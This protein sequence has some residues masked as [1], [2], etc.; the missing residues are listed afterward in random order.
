MFG[1]RR[2]IRVVDTAQHQRSS[3]QVP[4]A[5]RCHAK[6]GASVRH[7]GRLLAALRS[8][9]HWFRGTVGVVLL[10]GHAALGHH[11]PVCWHTVL[12]CGHAH[13]LPS[14]IWLP[15]ASTIR[16]LQTTAQHADCCCRAVVCGLSNTPDLS[17]L[18][19][20]AGTLRA[21]RPTCRT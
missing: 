20:H 12:C 3:G 17:A 14:T 11:G 1:K 21:S 5:G 19:A 4:R 7:Q 13:V 8:Y 16:T 9:S 10:V 6:G 2:P 18:T 15:T